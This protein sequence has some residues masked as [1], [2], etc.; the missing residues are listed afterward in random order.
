MNKPVATGIAGQNG[1]QGISSV[2]RYGIQSLL[3]K[4]VL[5]A[6][7]F[8]L[9]A[10]L[11]IGGFLYQQ[12]SQLQQ[13]QKLKELEQRSQLVTPVLR[14]FYYNARADVLMLDYGISLAERGL[15]EQAPAQKIPGTKK[16]TAGVAD[17]M[18][19]M[20]RMLLMRSRLYHKIS[21]FEVAE[22]ITEKISLTR[23][24]DKV[25]KSTLAL[26]TLGLNF[27]SEHE[28]LFYQGTEADVFQGR[29]AYFSPIALKQQ[30]KQGLRPPK[31][32]MKAIL[33]RYDSQS[34]ASGR[35]GGKEGLLGL[36]LLELDFNAYMQVL[37]D[38]PLA[39]LDF[40]LANADGDYLY[41]AQ[42]PDS[43][44][45]RPDG[46]RLQDEFPQLQA[47]MDKHLLFK[48][49]RQL[50]LATGAISGES[51]LTTDMAY[52]S[53]ISLA[54][55]GIA[56]HLNFLLRSPHH[57]YQ[58][59]VNWIQQQGFFLMLAWIILVLGL[60]VYG[61]RK[62]LAP[63][64]V[65]NDSIQGYEVSAK[66]DL[67]AG[68]RDEIGELSNSLS[69][70]FSTFSKQLFA[71]EKALS[72][73]KDFSAGLQG[74]LDSIA[75]AVVN[76]NPEGKIL[77][78]NQA[79]QRMFGY[80]E[81]EVKGKSIRVLM[82]DTK[83]RQGANAVLDYLRS[84]IN[85]VGGKGEELTGLRHDGDDFPMYLVLTEVMTR[86]GKLYTAMIRDVTANKLMEEERVQVLKKTKELAWRLDFALAAPGIGVWDY[87][88]LSGKVTWDERMYHLYGVEANC[89]LDP[90][91]LWKS[92]MH[93]DD[94]ETVE[95]K[96][97]ATV[98]TGKALNTTFRILLPGGVIKYIEVHAKAMSDGY[99]G[100]IRLVG[101]NIDVSEQQ[102]L[103]NLK[104]EALELAEESLRL[105]SEFLASMS[106][107]IRT[108]MNGVLGM[109]GLLEHTELSKQQQ[110][111]IEL[112]SSS[113]QSLLSLINDILDFSK[114]EAGKLELEII[115]FDLRTLL[116]NFAE[117][118]AV[119]SQE[120]NTELILDVSGL[121]FYMV[122][123]DPGRIRQILSNLVGNAIKFTSEGEIVI[124]AAIS[125]SGQNQSLMLHCSVT[126]TGIGIPKDKVGQLFDSFTQ[127]DSSTTRKYGGTGLGLAIVK[128]L[129]QLMDGDIRVSSELGQ[130]STFSFEICVRACEQKKVMMPSVDIKGTRI[131]IV[132]DNSTNLEVLKTQLEQW[133]AKVTQ[134]KSGYEAMALVEQTPENFFRVAILDMQMP[135]M[136]GATL[137]AKIHNHS[138]SRETKL[139]MMTSMGERGDAS[140]FAELGFCAY[141]PKPATTSDLFD[142]LTV[143]V[144]GK[145][146]LEVAQP[147]VTTHHLQSLK[148]N[149]SEGEVAADARILLVEDNQ[150]NQTVVQGILANLGIQADV[151]NNG[152]EA[153][154]KLNASKS[155]RLYQVI[156]MDCQMPEM[157]GYE[158]TR[159]I[160]H[161]AGGEAYLHV[162]VIAM[163]ANAMKGDK[164]KCLAAGMSDY[165][166][167][168]ID[169]DI[170]EQ[171][172]IYWLKEE[173]KLDINQYLTASR[174]IAAQTPAGQEQ[175]E[176]QTPAKTVQAK[177]APEQT[178]PATQSPSVFKDEPQDEI[179][180]KEGFLKRIRNNEEIARTLVNMFLEEMPEV[181]ESLYLAIAEKNFADVAAFAHKMNGTMK[182]I[183]GISSSKIVAKMEEVAKAG[184]INL[185][186]EMQPQLSSEFDK[187][188]TVLNQY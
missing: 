143:V 99:G 146:A 2:K 163:T 86:E 18:E 148:R 35:V 59:V 109:L 155:D 4:I 58:V 97:A 113:A 41:Y 169:G 187:F 95:A 165:T 185:L 166:T 107:E 83:G 38:G 106:H 152:L 188:M 160:R 26:Q 151:A 119:R 179:W 62:L 132:D 46:Y 142:A 104:Q 112:A 29:Q 167:K 20:F 140:Y 66:V 82:L 181:I 14:D 105:K 61:A 39:D 124:K 77:S 147:L 74:V 92:R 182:N 34:L 133:G 12:T 93:P 52:Y 80:Q 7:L 71:Q 81:E 123:G 94:L 32:V 111:Y 126:D 73:A 158:A 48:K 19:H 177:A 54:D 65:L 85:C 69:R 72:Q 47:V 68:R 55:L 135:G 172:L 56:G 84:G 116:G 8:C 79:A 176:Q 90:A 157:D 175:D 153:I 51:Q 63:L 36:I 127:V 128:Q 17:K 186:N 9:L 139:I 130:G 98:E 60:V 30:G 115:D 178:A 117:S 24:K 134:A 78:L 164:E 173:R 70:V 40:Y 76:I 11:G 96:V 44:S 21:Y 10:L 6:V 156:F 16:L 144:E 120:N 33:P 149:T 13:E 108:P 57:G 101:T 22:A 31:V 15:A 161:G 154:A 174:I 168:P 91:D 122:K 129:C 137:G 110:H 1:G 87:H 53:R 100:I 131:L 171:K 28:L 37:V 118:M 23:E 75:D 103:Q 184:D 25:V 150:I 89:G 121:D 5:A 170:I 27:I 136:D 162:P 159:K 125:E 102:N 88:V 183:G 180:D 67:P 43:L 141:F 49:L 50:T 42:S 3:V 145:E 114:I 64:Q 138:N 45:F